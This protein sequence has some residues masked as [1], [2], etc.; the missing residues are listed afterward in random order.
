MTINKDDL[1]ST[2]RAMTVLE[3]SQF[4]K[5]F[6]QEFG[7]TAAV[8]VSGPSP[9]GPP[10]AVPGEEPADESAEFDVVLD[11][12]GDRKVQVIKEV[13][14]LTKLGLKEAKDFVDAAPRVVL[15]GV[16]RDT[17][18]RARTVLIGVGASVTVKEK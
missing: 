6:E 18:D 3:L 1:L 5:A 14:T 17:A 8:S 16:D 13:R 15:E 7:V 11:S 9:A 10:P 12:V 2:F 4:V